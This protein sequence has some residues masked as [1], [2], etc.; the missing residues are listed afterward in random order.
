MSIVSYDGKKLSPAPFVNIT[1]TYTKKGSGEKIGATFNLSVKGKCL[2]FTGSPDSSGTF[3]TGSFYPPDARTD[4]TYTIAFT[5]N[6]ALGI[7]LRKQEAIRELFSEEGKS[8]E[9]Q[10]FNGSPPMKCNPRVVSVNF[11]EG[12]WYQDFDYVIELEADVMYIN[13]GEISEDEFNEQISA[14]EED[15][16]IETL[17][18]PQNISQVRMYKVSHNLSATGKRFYDQEGNPQEAWREA[19]KAVLNKLGFNSGVLDF[20]HLSGVRDLPDYFGQYNHVRTENINEGAGIYG[21]NETWL[22]ASGTAIE[23]FT[24]E[25]TKSRDSGLTKV[26]INGQIQ[27]LEVRSS[28]LELISNKYQ[29]ASGK[30]DE[31]FPLLPG[32]ARAYAGVKN[33]NIVPLSYTKSTNPAVGTINY[34]FE[35]DNRPSGMISHTLFEDVNIG[36]SFGADIFAAIPVVGRRAGPVLQDIYTK[37]ECT[38]N[39]SINLTFD[40][41]LYMS[42]WQ[43]NYRVVDVPHPR[44]ISPYSGEL[45]Y[46]VSFAKPLGNARNNL[47]T[48][49]T[50]QFVGEQTENWNPTTLNYTYNVNWTF[51]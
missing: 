10:S 12:L 25:Q 29:T 3:Y 2:V 20:L 38:R 14:F 1:R 32:R 7:M 40:R 24:V 8:F 39:F 37:K 28:G 42:G 46:L 11:A 17:E 45:N 50:K 44:N 5:E 48:L 27:G 43:Q 21:V 4:P 16:Q 33:M 47:G 23:T 9:I 41:D 49:A 26:V 19:R 36:E 30:Y 51:E 18:D 6:Q 31:I 13:G 35:Y 34:S 22:L 15:W